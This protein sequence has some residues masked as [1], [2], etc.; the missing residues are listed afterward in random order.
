MNQQNAL[1][2]Y[3]SKVSYFTGKLE[4]YLRYKEIPYRFKAMTTEYFNQ[5]VPEKTGAQQMPAVQPAPPARAATLLAAT[6][7][8]NRTPVELRPRSASALWSW[9]ESLRRRWRLT[10]Q[11]CKPNFED[12]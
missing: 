8:D 7:G 3:G 10:E 1:T 6:V 9:P 11:P 4:G 5:L 12:N 2:V